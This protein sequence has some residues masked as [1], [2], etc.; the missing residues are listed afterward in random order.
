MCQGQ[1]SA[2]GL[3]QCQE[4]GLLLTDWDSRAK[5]FVSTVFLEGEKRAQQ[6]LA[7]VRELILGYPKRRSLTITNTCDNNQHHT[8]VK[9]R[10]HSLRN[11]VHTVPVMGEPPASGDHKNLSE[12]RTCGTFL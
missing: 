9:G 5:H 7:A 10:G 6:L 3:G 11:D 2:L 8:L 4:T 1:K 12:C